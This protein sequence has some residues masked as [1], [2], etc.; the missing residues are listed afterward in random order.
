MLILQIRTTD[1]FAIQ[2]GYPFLTSD[3]EQGFHFNNFEK[4]RLIDIILSLFWICHSGSIFLICSSNYFNLLVVF[5]PFLPFFLYLLH[6]FCLF[7]THNS[8]VS[9]MRRFF[10][11]DTESID[12]LVAYLVHG[13]HVK[14]DFWPY[15]PAN[16]YR[17][18]GMSTKFW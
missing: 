18:I 9:L 3:I 2:L 14:I 11:S 12:F 13:M 6:L 15:Y 7:S 8:S 5:L 1:N 17:L 10:G 16:L 4:H